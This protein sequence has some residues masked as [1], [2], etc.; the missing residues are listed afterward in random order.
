MAEGWQPEER[1]AGAELYLCPICSTRVSSTARDCPNCHAIFV[2]E[3][4][5]APGAAPAVAPPTPP[6]V[7][8]KCPNCD[9]AVG[10]NDARCPNCGAIFVDTAPE[11][12]AR[13]EPPR[14][15]PA[16]AP[17]ALP[18]A[19]PARAV[20]AAKPAKGP[21]KALA[22]P[23]PGSKG[24]ASA[25]RTAEARKRR[26]S[27]AIERLSVRRRRIAQRR[28]LGLASMGCGVAIYLGTLILTAGGGFTLVIGTAIGFSIL[29]LALGVLITYNQFLAERHYREQLEKARVEAALLREMAKGPAAAGAAAVAAAAA[30]AAAPPSKAPAVGARTI[31]PPPPDRKSGG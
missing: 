24:R 28:M 13:P 7:Q 9:G 3:G 19:A 10:E 8:Y 1:G 20:G 5:G 25:A 29:L 31:A 16:R 27:K 4:E 18:A 23:K 26:H 30:T 12:P 15:P 6:A 2:E 22:V 21:G 17:A 11:P 14:A